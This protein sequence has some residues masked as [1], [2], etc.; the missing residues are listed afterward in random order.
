MDVVVTRR[1]ADGVQ[2]GDGELELT[3]RN[4]DD[5]ACDRLSWME[6]VS[7]DDPPYAS[8]A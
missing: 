3:I 5:L 8:R 1:V 2:S 6:T 7:H 4:P